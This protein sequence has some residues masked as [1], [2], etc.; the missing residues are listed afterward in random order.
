MPVQSLDV[1][2]RLER[3]HARLPA[4]LRAAPIVVAVS[5]GADSTALLHALAR[6]AAIAT[7]R[8]RAVHV[9]H[10][11]RDAAS[12][13]EDL[14]R[15]MALALSIGVP[16][17]VERVEVAPRGDGAPGSEN[18][19][20]VARYRALGHAARTVGAATIALGHHGD[21]QVE[22]ILLH[23]LRG[24]GAAGLR[25][26]RP[27][28][29]MSPGVNGGAAG[30]L[31]WR[32]LLGARH[33]ELVRYCV[34]H[35]LVYGH[36]STNDDRRYTRNRLRHTV[37]PV[38]E[39]ATPGAT[40]SLSRAANILGVEDEYLEQLTER[41]WSQIV[42][43]RADYTALNRAPLREEH[44]AIQRRLVRR[45]WRHAAGASDGLPWQHTEAMLALLVGPQSGGRLDLPHGQQLI[46]NRTAGY[47]GPRATLVGA[48][49]GSFSAPLV[50]REWAVELDPSRAT[51]VDLPE[52]PY[53]LAV[54]PGEAAGD[55]PL[56][57]E[58]SLPHGG[59]QALVL[60][61]RRAG[62]VVHLPHGRQR[63]LQN[64]FVDRHVPAYLRNELV[65]LAQG[66]AI[67]WIAGVHSF[68]M[69]PTS[70]GAAAP[71]RVVVTLDT[72]GAAVAPVRD[73]AWQQAGELQK[74]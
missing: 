38:L 19:A 55:E 74:P 11:L 53:R 67:F 62:D 3:E 25:G 7:A 41:A 15:V 32:P 54:R 10:G 48:L 71:L 34:E 44:L 24:S 14:A 35:Q 27:L 68:P 39:P 31:L 49:R 52:G 59:S 66:N 26:M 47:L 73:V 46:V 58:L 29:A 65:L 70:R 72:G 57:L 45:A 51:V 30:A 18:A 12:R 56:A 9:D 60:R 13:A 6:S 50:P 33:A 16:L 8:L 36:D 22:T 40:N 63:S 1:V 43:S 61:T 69:R 28:H 17:T 37:V 64:W 4:R 5:G 42:S 20:R 21:D 2:T 23:L